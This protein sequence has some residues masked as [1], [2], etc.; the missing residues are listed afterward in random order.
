MRIIALL[1]FLLYI[2]NVGCFGFFD[3]LNLLL[4]LLLTVLSQRN[5]IFFC[6]KKNPVVFIDVDDANGQA[7]KHQNVVD[8]I[9]V[10]SK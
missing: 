8:E 1:I 5:R 2:Y 4:L 7:F 6:R 9:I 3:S 10:C